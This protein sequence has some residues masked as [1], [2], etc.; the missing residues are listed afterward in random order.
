MAFIEV[1]VD[2]ED[3]LDEVTADDLIAELKRRKLNEEHKRQLCELITIATDK[4]ELESAIFALRHKDY[5]TA[6]ICLERA[7]P[8][9]KGLLWGVK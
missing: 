1:E 8:Q 5:E 6:F 7:I 2:I 3:Y 4:E 9:L